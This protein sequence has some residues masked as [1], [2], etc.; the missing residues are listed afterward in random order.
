MIARGLAADARLLVLDE[1]TASLTDEEIDHLAHGRCRACATHG[2]AIVY[3]S[4]RLD[5]IFAMTDRVTRD[6]RRRR[7]ST[8]R[9]TADLDKAQLIEQITG[10]T[11]SRSR[12]G[13]PQLRTPPG[14]PSCWRSRA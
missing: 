5:E 9:T 8:D 11:R 6:A 13:S 7:S 14:A 10:A 2:V 3:V 12:S 1:P 4:H